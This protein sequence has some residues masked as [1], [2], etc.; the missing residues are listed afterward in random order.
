MKR[1]TECGKVLS[2]KAKMC[3]NCGAPTEANANTNNTLTIIYNGT[4]LLIDSSIRLL[5]NGN[6][7]GKYSYKKGFGVEIP[8]T[9]GII[10]IE[11]KSLFR[12]STH[13]FKALPNTNYT[14]YVTYN[15]YVGKFKYKKTVDNGVVENIPNIKTKKSYV[16]WAACILL[17][18][19]SLTFIY[20]NII[21]KEEETATETVPPRKVIVPKSDVKVPCPICKR[22]PE[23][24]MEADLISAGVKCWACDNTGYAS[25]DLLMKYY[26]D[27]QSSTSNE[28]SNERKCISCHGTGKCHSCAGNG[29]RFY[30]N[31]MG[32][33][34]G[35]CTIC[36][37]SG[38][39]DLCNGTGRY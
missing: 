34:L 35:K 32:Q 27:N 16:S 37:H 31:G 21:N 13:I 1:S 8:I 14:C 20:N 38:K 19:L 18:C 9:S 30:D 22:N 4:W 17:A 3:P 25:V 5:V 23:H 6:E 26:I 2:D 24:L 39:C 15:R 7:I 36:N 28:S 33:Y 10:T 11:L 12:T 29:M